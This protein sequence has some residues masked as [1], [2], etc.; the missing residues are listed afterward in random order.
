[1]TIKALMDTSGV[2]FGTSGARGPVSAMTNEVCYAYASAFLQ[3]LQGIGDLR[4]GAPVAVG[5]DLRASTARIM[6]AVGRAIV[7]HRYRLVNAGQLPT[8]ALAYYGMLHRMPTVMVTGSHIPEDRNGIKFTRASGEITKDDEAQISAQRVALPEDDLENAHLALPPVSGDPAEQYLR[9]YTDFFGDGALAGKTVGLYEHSTVA[10]EPIHDVLTA[11][12]AKVVQFGYSQAFLPVD[13]EAI[14]PEDVALARRWAADNAVDCIVSADGD[15]DRPLISDE[16]GEWLRGDM[17]GLLC[18]SYLGADAVVTPVSSNSAVEKS[19]RFSTVKRTRIGSPYVIAGME[20]VASAGAKC[21][22]GYEANGGVLVGS[23]VPREDRMLAALP[24]RDALIALLGVLLLSA[25]SQKPIA[26]LVA[27]LPQRF[28]ASDRLKAFSP[29]RSERILRQLHSG[30]HD[31]DLRMIDQVFSSVAGKV[32]AVD[33]TDGLRMTFVN[34][35]IIHLRPSGNAPEFRCYTESSSSQR[36]LELN[37]A[38]LRIIEAW[39]AARH[40]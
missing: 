16:N 37:Q 35:D 39:P 6:G 40:D 4:A 34:E 31:R 11:L 26:Q 1:M 20:A 13:T 14:R 33:V 36:V 32:S 15:G 29:E 21:V 30:D 12:G 5:G 18:A 27:D 17:V 2:R 7:D 38:C 23:D 8:P 9:R 3:Y 19:G 28:T 10:R 24:T 25:E 22:V